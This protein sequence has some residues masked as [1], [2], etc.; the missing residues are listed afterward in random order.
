MVLYMSLFL[1]TFSIFHLSSLEVCCRWIFIGFFF[2]V[3]IKLL[4]T[5]IPEADVPVFHRMM[6]TGWR[7]SSESYSCFRKIPTDFIKN[8][9]IIKVTDLPS[10]YGQLHTT[11]F[12]LKLYE[13][14]DYGKHKSI[15][16]WTLSK[17]PLF[18]W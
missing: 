4:L 9:A 15:Y 12:S 18:K 8:F 7:Q 2:S 3:Y 10:V 5:L 14:K 16:K 11:L 17:E 1:T 13:N 6:S